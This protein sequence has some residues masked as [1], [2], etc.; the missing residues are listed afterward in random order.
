MWLTWD[1]L[2]QIGFCLICGV[3]AAG[4]SIVSVFTGGAT[5]WNTTDFYALAFWVGFALPQ[6]LNTDLFKR[7]VRASKA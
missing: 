6:I 5:V 1:E 7:L 2:F 4:I 3:I